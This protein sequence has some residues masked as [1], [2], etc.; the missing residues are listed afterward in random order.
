[1][2]YIIA[3]ILKQTM[4]PDKIIL[5][6]GREKFPDKKL[7]KI[8]DKLKACGVELRFC[9]EDIE[10][11]TKY[12]YAMQEYLEGRTLLEVIRDD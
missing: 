8:F 6:L 3:S 11:H 12:F 9:P 1:M 7:P 10:P 5:W 4:K 2:P